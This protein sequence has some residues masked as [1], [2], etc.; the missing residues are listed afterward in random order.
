MSSAT[1][2]WPRVESARTAVSLSWMTLGMTALLLAVQISPYWYPT[3][4]SCGYLSIARNLAQHQ[5]LRNLGSDQLYYSLG[6]PLLISPVFLVTDNPFL[7]ISL[8]HFGLGLLLMGGV[9]LWVRKCV[10][11]AASWIVM[12]SLVNV[13]FW[14]A[15]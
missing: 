12:L 5:T 1:L 4:D 14:E 13:S 3:P 11:E 10:P 9:W 8:I 6:Y 2:V 7:L 15:N